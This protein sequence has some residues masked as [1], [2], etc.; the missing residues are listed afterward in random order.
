VHGSLRGPFDVLDKILNIQK[1]VK[2]IITLE[3]KRIFFGALTII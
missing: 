1:G 3:E 2:T